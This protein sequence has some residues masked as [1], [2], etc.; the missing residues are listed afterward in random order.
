LPAFPPTAQVLF[1]CV[2]YWFGGLNR[3][4]ADFFA[5]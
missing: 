4:A 2:A 1:V 3:V 5:K